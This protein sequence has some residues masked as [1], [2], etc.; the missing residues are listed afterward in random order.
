MVIFVANCSGEQL[1]TVEV[2]AISAVSELKLH[3]AKSLG[4]PLHRQFLLHN[5]IE[6]RVD[7][8]LPEVPV[9][10]EDW[11]TLVV[12]SFRT[13]LTASWDGSAKLWNADNGECVV[14]F[15]GH[16]SVL[17]AAIHS[18]EHAIVLTASRDG[19]AKL[20]SVMCGDCLFTL[21]GH[22]SHVSCVR[23]SSD[24][25]YIL[26][27]SMDGTVK[28]WSRTTGACLK[29][30]PDDG[31][32][33]TWV[34]FCQDGFLSLCRSGVA[35]L[36]ELET[37]DCVRSWTCHGEG[38]LLGDF[39]GDGTKM[40][41]VSWTEEDACYWCIA[42]GQLLQVFIGHRDGVISVLF[43]RH[44]G[45][46]SVLTTS[47]DGSAKLWEADSGRCLQTFV[48]GDVAVTA[49]DLVTSGSDDAI[50]VTASVHGRA[51]VWNADTGI[52][53]RTFEGHDV[54]VKSV[55]LSGDGS[56][57]LTA[58]TDATAKLW[59]VAT[60]ECVQTFEGHSSCLTIA[61]F[62]DEL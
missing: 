41:T 35:K 58:S 60:G 12:L 36:W 20:W 48:D 5:G 52:C 15:N 44:R 55:C 32:P 40:V 27:S 16:V 9:R 4:I 56:L 49:A 43:C 57:A 59:C 8:S 51:K 42:K 29:S 3:L 53:L 39:S 26:T 14:S 18:V 23:L 38:W 62:C 50:V 30:C 28:V 37:N 24:G 33:V 17:N 45:A 10:D 1:A 54:S 11:I 7:A 19:T 6:L 31:K 47:K 34:S 25:E 46:D 2:G 13:I 61:S 22:T 21:E